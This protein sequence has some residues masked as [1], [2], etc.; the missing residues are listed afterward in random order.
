MITKRDLGVALAAATFSLAAAA[1][2]QAPK[3]ACAGG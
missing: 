2:A 1:F 3:P